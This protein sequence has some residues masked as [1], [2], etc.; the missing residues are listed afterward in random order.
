MQKPVLSLESLNNTWWDTQECTSEAADRSGGVLSPFGGISR[1]RGAQRRCRAVDRSYHISG[2]QQAVS[3]LENLNSTWWDTYECIS[4]AVDRSGG[5]L[6]SVLPCT[7]Q[8]PRLKT[9]CC[10]H[11]IRYAR[12]TARQH[13]CLWK[14]PQVGRRGLRSGWPLQRRIYKCPS[15]YS[16]SSKA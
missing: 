6:M 14:C 12:S 11:E 7:V 1:H 3:S 13:L 15:M 16:S 4:G 9:H 5:A 8:V 2:I 10:M